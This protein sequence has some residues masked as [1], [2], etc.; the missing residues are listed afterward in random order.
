MERADI[1]LRIYLKLPGI[2]PLL[3]A[4]VQT[5]QIALQYKTE[6]HKNSLGGIAFAGRQ[7]ARSYLGRR[8]LLSGHVQQTRDRKQVPI[9]LN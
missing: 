1:E 5:E 9:Q 8:Q 7:L 3:R 6:Q 2:C 4:D